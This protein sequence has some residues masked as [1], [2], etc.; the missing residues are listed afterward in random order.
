M[1]YRKAKIAL[2]VAVCPLIPPLLAEGIGFILGCEVDE[3]G[4]S[5]CGPIGPVLSGMFVLGWGL[6]ITFLPGIVAAVIYFVRGFSVR[7]SET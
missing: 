4:G 3:G 7:N 6:I 2:F 1:H 5:G